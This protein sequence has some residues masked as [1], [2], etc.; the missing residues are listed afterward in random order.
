MLQKHPEWFSN[1]NHENAAVNCVPSDSIFILL[2]AMSEEQKLIFAKT[3]KGFC[4]K[5][6]SRHTGNCSDKIC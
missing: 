3:N 4:L 1:E 6:K 2:Y 5:L